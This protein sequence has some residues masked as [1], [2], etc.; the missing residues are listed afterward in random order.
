MPGAG[1]EPAR[2]LRTED[3]E[4]SA[5]TI[6]PPRQISNYD[7]VIVHRLECEFT[8]KADPLI[9]G[10]ITQ[11]IHIFGFA[12]VDIVGIDEVKNV[13]KIT[14]AL[15]EF[16]REFVFFKRLVN[17]ANLEHVF[18]FQFILCFKVA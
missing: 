15:D 12:V 16:H 11:S 4:S 18:L 6:S 14:I 10:Q 3:F 2:P 9:L 7:A 1:L 13:V 17:A 8:P 5:S